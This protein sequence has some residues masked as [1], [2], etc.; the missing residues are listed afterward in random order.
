MAFAV[1]TA[2]K[3]TPKNLAKKN[4]VQTFGE[5]ILFFGAFFG[6]FFNEQLFASKSKKFAESVLQERSLNTLVGV[7]RIASDSC[8]RGR[9]LTRIG[10]DG[11]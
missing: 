1:F 9:R 2:E 8:R 4:R 3:R 6:A 11:F 5:N 10:G 7:P